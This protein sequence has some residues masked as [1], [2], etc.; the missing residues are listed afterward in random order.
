MT[1]IN[2]NVAGVRD[3]GIIGDFSK[4]ITGIVRLTKIDLQ[5]EELTLENEFLLSMDKAVRSSVSMEKRIWIFGSRIGANGFIA[6]T[7]C[8][9]G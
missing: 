7:T 2:V 5:T 1:L 3:N 9:P 4:A 6:I 8:F